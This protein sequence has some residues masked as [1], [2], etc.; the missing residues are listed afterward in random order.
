MESADL[1]DA[2]KQNKNVMRK[3]SGGARIN[4]SFRNW[5]PR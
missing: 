4:F 1:T 5:K 3:R 2:A